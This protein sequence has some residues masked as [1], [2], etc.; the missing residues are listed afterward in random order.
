MGNRSVGSAPAGVPST[1]VRLEG[2]FVSASICIPR[3]HAHAVWVLPWVE[4]ILRGK[5][6]PE[7]MKSPPW[8]FPASGLL[9]QALCRTLLELRWAVPNWRTGELTVDPALAE[10]F[11]GRGRVGLAQRLF[12]AEFIEGQWWAEGLEGTIFSRQTFVQFDWDGR[13]PV[14]VVV[15]ARASPSSLVDSARPSLRDLLRKL[16]RVESLQG[17]FDRAF[18]ASPLIAGERKEILFEVFG[19][20][21]RLVPPELVDLVPALERRR[22]GLLNKR[23]TLNT[24]FVE[25]PSSPVEAIDQMLSKLDAPEILYGPS[26]LRA[27]FASQLSVE[28]QRRA[29]E[30]EDWLKTGIC[31]HLV[32]GPTHRHFDA[33]REICSALSGTRNPHLLLSSAFLSPASLRIEGGLPSVLATAPAETRFTILYGHASDDPP[34]RQSRDVDEW[35]KALHAIAPDL[36]PRVEL[37]AGERRSHEKVVISSI[38]EWMLGS[39]NA[40]SSRP[41]LRTFECSLRGSGRGIAGQLLERLSTNMP[42][43]RREHVVQAMSFSDGCEST[44]TGEEARKRVET[45]KRV[46]EAAS[47]IA[48]SSECSDGESARRLSEALR[49]LHIAMRPFRRTVHLKVVDEHQTRDVLVALLQSAQNEVLAATDRLS[50]G[51]LDAPTLRALKERQVGLRLVW[52]RE[53]GI[54][55]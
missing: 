2:F 4:E 39:W 26:Q 42:P 36:Q 31:C 16:G 41:D 53:S 9:A 14:D 37:I 19:D 8:P 28:I 46:A 40:C 7:L 45:L 55:R 48:Q 47:A 24:R 52:G 12:D 49:G 23:E 13:T 29:S 27:K 51:A 30:M 32:A 20:D 54:G 38:G 35:L 11:R 10:A 1:R 3:S 50:D 15:P 33:L 18:L 22:P 6:L 25:L 43:S 5:R 44:V 34:E 17:K 21:R